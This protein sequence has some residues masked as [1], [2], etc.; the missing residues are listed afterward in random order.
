MVIVMGER[1]QP[2]MTM[3]IGSTNP[4]T[5]IGIALFMRIDYCIITTL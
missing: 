3:E 1:F 2:E 5:L 4:I